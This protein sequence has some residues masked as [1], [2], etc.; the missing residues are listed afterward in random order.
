MHICAHYTR[1]AHIH[2]HTPHVHT[3]TCTHNTH[4]YVNTHMHTP[5]DP[6]DFI[7]PFN[8]EER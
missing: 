6:R 8:R 4:V 2:V 7:T 5:T 1:D 3:Y